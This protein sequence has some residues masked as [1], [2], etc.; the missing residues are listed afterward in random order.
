MRKKLVIL[1]CLSFLLLALFWGV[2]IP[3]SA[4][5]SSEG[6]ERVIRVYGEAEITAEPDVAR[7]ILAVETRSQSAK[8]AAEENARLMDAVLS[9]LKEMGLEEEQLKTGAYSIYSYREA[10]EPRTQEQQITHYRATNE[11]N[12]TLHELDKTGPVIDTA[13]QAGANQVRSIHFDLQDP[14]N[15]QLEALKSATSQA[16]TKARAIAESAGVTIR[17]IKSISEDSV[18]YAP[19]RAEYRDDIGLGEAEAAPPTPITPGDVT[20]RARVTAEYRF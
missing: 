2:G 1:C 13:V 20:V 16:G 4:G 9:A 3:A 19:F 11:L 18:Y 6:Q 7:I 12:I 10:V 15:M 5:A 8:E 14:E 17:E